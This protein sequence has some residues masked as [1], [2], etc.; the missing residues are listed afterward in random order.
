MYSNFLQQIVKRCQNNLGDRRWCIAAYY[1]CMRNT[2]SFRN[3]IHIDLFLFYMHTWLNRHAISSISAC[4]RDK[5][6]ANSFL[7]DPLAFPWGKLGSNF[8]YHLI[9]MRLVLI[10]TLKWPP[11]VPRC[12]LIYQNNHRSLSKAWEVVDLYIKRD[13][14]WKLH[15]VALYASL[16]IG[17]TNLDW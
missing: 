1:L 10:N 16:S 14:S 9:T 11:E 4:F 2:S 5:N 7:Y 12:E 15:T 3:I 8:I 6:F 13:I 17:T